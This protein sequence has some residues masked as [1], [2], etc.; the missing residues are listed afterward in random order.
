MKLDP[1]IRL[2]DLPIPPESKPT[3]RWS[4]QMI[5]MADHI[6]PYRTLLILDRL[7]GQRVF[8]P[9][10]PA[11]NRMAEVIDREGVAI[12]SRIYGGTE[13]LLPTAR[14]VLAEARRAPVIAAIRRGEITKNEAIP[15]L[16]IAL[17]RLVGILNRSCEGTADHY[18][19]GPVL[20]PRD[21]NQLDL[22]RQPDSD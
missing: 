2:H 10:D 7:G 3:R 18:S 8:V 4:P 5:E 13:I 17:K 9:R 14:E 6:G 19:V 16:G 21:E 12:M 22:F 11:N 20:R 15:I 1:P